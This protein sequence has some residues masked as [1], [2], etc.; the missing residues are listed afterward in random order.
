MDIY[1][2]LGVEP[3]I[4]AAGTH[5]RL[6]GS[7]M[8][9][10]VTDAM[11]EASR[12]FVDIEELHLA[13][14]KRIS[15]LIGVEAA[16][17]CGCCAAAIALMA[18]ACMAGSDPAKIL[19]L[20]DT[21][22]MKNK[23]VVQRGHRNRFDQA[24]RLAGG[25][26]VEIGPTVSELES[27][28]NEDVAA[29]SYSFSWFLPDDGI[30]LAEA[31]RTAHEAGVPVI[32]DAAAQIPPLDSLT[33][34]LCE[35]ADLVAFSGGKALRGPQSSGLVLGRRDLVEAC[36]LN[37][38]PNHGVGRPMK[39]GKEDIVG[40]VKAVELYVNRDHAVEM[41]LWEGRVAH[42][43]DTLSELPHVTAERIM[44]KGVGMQI[45]HVAIAW[46]EASL[47]LTYGD[48]VRELR[49]GRPR[50][51]V[52]FVTPERYPALPGAELRVGP[53]MLREGEA[54]VVDARLRE[55]LARA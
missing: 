37:D 13:A 42:V 27:A 39:T 19:Q 31:A 15:E 10:E 52:T 45:P 50:I 9:P 5:T 24:L 26:F 7:V 40:L 17:V 16:H 48:V 34:F 32:V 1:T 38:C 14:G 18:A 2:E 23:F 55:L 11:A 41:A 46:D 51:D 3:I 43:I 12:V 36:R 28:L 35:G 25:R 6:G 21:T 47:G 54:V 49:G 30:P 8:H 22:G 20:P 33:R 4:N 44:P 53:H 29:V